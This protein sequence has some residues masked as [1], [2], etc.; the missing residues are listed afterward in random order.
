MLLHAASLLLCYVIK[1][2]MS[3][4][5]RIYPIIAQLSHSVDLVKPIKKAAVNFNY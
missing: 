2:K 1:F 5:S 4:S 3:R